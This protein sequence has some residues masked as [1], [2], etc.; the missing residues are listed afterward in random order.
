MSDDTLLIVV[1]AG[2][3]L[4]ALLGAGGMMLL[5][6]IAPDAQ[7]SGPG[8]HGGGDWHLEPPPGPPR[9]GPP[10]VDAEPAPVR[11]RGPRQL[12]PQARRRRP[13]HAPG[14]ARPDRVTPRP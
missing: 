4:L 8:D 13:W 14:R 6:L 9:G 5:V 2:M 10:L 3:H 11:L 1:L 7:G 12:V